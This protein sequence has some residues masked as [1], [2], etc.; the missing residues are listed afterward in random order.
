[1]SGQFYFNGVV[2]LIFYS[3]TFML[4]PE[5]FYSDK[6]FIRKAFMVNSWL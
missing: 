1:M 5:Y 2:Y 4:F 6:L 3:Q